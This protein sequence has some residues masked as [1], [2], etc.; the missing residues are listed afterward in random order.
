MRES[1]DTSGRVSTRRTNWFRQAA[2]RVG[3]HAHDALVYDDWQDVTDPL[4]PLHPYAFAQ[5]LCPDCGEDG[6]SEDLVDG[7]CPS[8]GS[9]VERL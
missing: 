2:E 8:C 9:S 1:S 3:R 6:D 5:W 4:N 7:R